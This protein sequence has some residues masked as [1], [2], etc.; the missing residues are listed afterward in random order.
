[1]NN[2]NTSNEKEPKREYTEEE[3]AEFSRLMYRTAALPREAR[4]NV[5]IYTMG[6][7]AM[8]ELEGE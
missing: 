4:K 3:F 5:A 7:L 1:M 2:K 6:I 8:A